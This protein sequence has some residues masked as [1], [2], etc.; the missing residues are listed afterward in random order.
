MQSYF[1]LTGVIWE[2]SSVK[3]LLKVNFCVVY[4]PKQHC[5]GVEG[6]DCVFGN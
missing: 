2:L 6:I 5:V 3:A 4:N 1:L